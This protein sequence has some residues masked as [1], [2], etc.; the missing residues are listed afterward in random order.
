VITTP[1]GFPPY[2]ENE[3]TERTL[4]VG[5]VRLKG[6]GPTPRCVIPTLEQGDLG[7]APHALRTP[8]AENLV[9]SFGLGRL[10]CAGAYFQVVTVGTIRVGDPVTATPDPHG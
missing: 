6:M 10:P 9:E 4:T 2:A 7:R 1:P 5:T 8:A 3:W